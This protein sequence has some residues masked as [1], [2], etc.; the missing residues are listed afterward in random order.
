MVKIRYLSDLHLEF[1]KEHKIV[2]FIN[3]NIKPNIEEVCILTGDIGNPYKKNYDVFMNFINISFKK[4]FVITGN[5]EYYNKTKTIEETNIYLIEYFKQFDNITFL[6]NSYEYYEDYCFIG[7]T[8]W[9][10]ITNPIYEINDVFNIP[11]FDYIKYNELNKICVEF[12]E[13]TLENNSNCIVI[14]HHMPLESLINDKY[15]TLQ[16]KP[17]NQWF[18]CDMNELITK[19]KDKIKCW[20]YGHTHTPLDTTINDIPFLCNPIGYPNE[21]KKLDFQKVIIMFE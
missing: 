3:N 6:N 8:L 12:L 21:N 14:T 15:K 11:N 16:M 19:Q 5:H 2:K 7:T 18:Y 1:I 17:Y 4:T 20:I 9:S 10:K 13:Q